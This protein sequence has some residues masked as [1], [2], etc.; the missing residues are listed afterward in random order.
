MRRVGSIKDRRVRVR[1]VAA[2]NRDLAG[3][4]A[5]KR[6]REDLYYRINVLTICVPPLRERGNDVSLLTQKL[7]GPG[8]EWEPE[9]AAAVNAYH[10]PGNVR[11]L[12]N[13]VERAKILADNEMI[14]LKNLPPDVLAAPTG[15]RAVSDT[16]DGPDGGDGGQL[17]LATVTRARIAEALRQQR[18]NKL[19]AAKALGVSRRSLYRLLEKYH[20]TE[21]ELSAT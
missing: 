13:A 18:G 1:I 19:R 6:F 3:E 10:W 8:W 2:T 5:E 15:L 7:T 12:V 14:R 11:Q 4:V 16:R 20:F 21:N 17:D 9:A